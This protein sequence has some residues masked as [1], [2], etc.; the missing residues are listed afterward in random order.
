LTDWKTPLLAPVAGDHHALSPAAR[1]EVL[2]LV[3]PRPLRFLTRLVL[4]WATIVAVIVLAVRADSWPVTVA[5]IVAVATR[6]IVLGLLI[7]EQVHDLG[8]PQCPGDALVNLLAGFPL[9]LLTVEGYAQVHLAHHKYYFTERDPDFVRKS[10]PAWAIPMTPGRL[11]G[12]LVTD[13]LG[14]NLFALMKGKRAMGRRPEFNRP[15]APPAALRAV[16]YLV[17]AG[18]I[19]LL[20]GW[21][22]VVL[23]WIVPLLTV[24]QALV[25]WGALC[26]HKYNLD[27]PSVAESSPIVVVRWWER[28]L[29]P[30]LNFSLHPY[31]HYFPGIPFPDLPRV[32]A[33]FERE[34]LVDRARVFHGYAAFLRFLVRSS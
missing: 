22:V 34:G 10:G 23:Y 7:H 26:E 15:A 14:L 18:V 6:Q 9:L 17:A 2:A 32:H 3:R 11:A 4:T 8:L 29:L 30:N 16:Y 27:R 12:L 5:A 21:A 19:T 1:D 31:H 13:L 28:L 24:T 33:I 25:R 20:A